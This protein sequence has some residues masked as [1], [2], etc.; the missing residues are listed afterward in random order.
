[1]A[2]IVIGQRFNRLVVINKEQSNKWGKVRWKC[3]CDCGNETIVIATHLKSG[4]TG[5][6]GC[7]RNRQAYNFKDITGNKYGK[8]TV[9]RRSTVK[10]Y[11][12]T[13]WVCKCDCGTVKDITGH[14]LKA[15]MTKSCGCIVDEL[16]RRKGENSPSFKRGYHTHPDGYLI[17]TI[18]DF[19]GKSRNKAQH[20]VIMENHIGR[21]LK[22]NETVHHKNGIRS[23]NKIDNLELWASKHPSGQRVEDMINFCL[24]YLSEYAPEHLIADSITHEEK[25]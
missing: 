6:C 16:R 8:L 5:S 3:Q 4:M 11:D 2:S 1:M 22:A 18:R 15:G 23:D 14:A 21:L 19:D 7:L 24:Q 12:R 9:L 25:V 10:N 20:K 17:M 13:T